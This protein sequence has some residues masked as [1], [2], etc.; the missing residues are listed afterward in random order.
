MIQRKILRVSIGRWAGSRKY[1]NFVGPARVKPD[2]LCSASV[3]SFRPFI[4]EN[5]S[6]TKTW[7]SHDFA[8]VRV[9]FYLYRGK[10]PKAHDFVGLGSRTHDRCVDEQG[11]LAAWQAQFN[12]RRCCMLSILLGQV[13]V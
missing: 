3:Y 2:Q 5:V 9:A 1:V 12:T 13:Q 11:C 4:G 6:A 10:Q 8:E 7:F